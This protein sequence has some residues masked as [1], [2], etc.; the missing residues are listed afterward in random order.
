MVRYSLFASLCMAM[1]IGGNLSHAD[2]A[3]YDDLGLLAQV[4][5]EMAVLASLVEQYAE[6]RGEF[7]RYEQWPGWLDKIE[8]QARF[9]V[10][11]SA[12]YPYGYVYRRTK[13][14]REALVRGGAVPKSE[15]E[16]LALSHHS[17]RPGPG[18]PDLEVVVSKRNTAHLVYHGMV[19]SPFLVP[20]WYVAG[21]G[22]TGRAATPGP[23]E[24]DWLRMYSV[25]L[26]NGSRLV[27]LGGQALWERGVSKTWCVKAIVF[28]VLFCLWVGHCVLLFRQLRADRAGARRALRVIAVVLVACTAVGSWSRVPVVTGS[29]GIAAHGIYSEDAKGRYGQRVAELFRRWALDQDARKAFARAGQFS[30]ARQAA[31]NREHG[32]EDANANNGR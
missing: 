14:L 32:Q 26:G 22:V 24:N 3:Y 4:R 8:L 28:V 25:G 19:L 30:E 5:S 27:S 7:P 2:A 15:G 10:G 11:T 17:T 29:A 18:I 12:A 21:D 16:F 6:A 13:E 1:M 23:G 20:Y 31:W 9:P